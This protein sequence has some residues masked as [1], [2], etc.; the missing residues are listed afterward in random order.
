MTRLLLGF[1]LLM[2]LKGNALAQKD[3]PPEPSLPE[4]PE[5]SDSGSPYQSTV[6]A[7][8]PSP[9]WTQ[10]RSF[11]STR[12]WLLDPGSYE[13]QLW[14]RTRIPH[15]IGGT[16]GPADLLMQAEVEVGLV[17]HLQLDVYEN[18]TFDV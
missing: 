10:D 8:R 18:L 12:F 3:A 4:K 16:R 2:G 15:Q 7:H 9:S 11:T 1:V 5:D 17:P 13:A 14:F 6:K